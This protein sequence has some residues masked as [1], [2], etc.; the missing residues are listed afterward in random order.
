MHASQAKRTKSEFL[1]TVDHE[2][3]TPMNSILG[4]AD[5]LLDTDLDS[6]QKELVL[7]SRKCGKLLVAMVEH[8]IEYTKLREG[9]LELAHGSVEL[10]PLIEECIDAGSEYIVEQE[11]ELEI[12]YSLG[13]MVPK[14]VVTDR[15]HLVQLVSE[16]LRIAIYFIEKGE[17][18][19]RTTADA[20]DNGMQRVYFM[21][22]WASGQ[23][24]PDG[25]M[26]LHSLFA[27][28][29]EERALHG[30][31]LALGLEVVRELGHLFQGELYHHFS[32]QG[33]SSITF[34]LNVPVGPI[35]DQCF[36]PDRRFA[37]KRMLAVDRSRTSLEFI[38]HFGE[39]W[40]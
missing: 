37:G 15:N 6:K 25:L 21:V 4:I 12:A 14:V 40:E 23:V 2:I 20:P 30:G 22:W 18:S 10:V 38:N 9:H 13:N 5:M 24:P 16:L 33:M 35:G 11:K 31:E 7:S 27:V 28:E 26:H 34:E 8:I 3:R 19:V 39:E 36:Q 29:G 17:V 32:E 1:A